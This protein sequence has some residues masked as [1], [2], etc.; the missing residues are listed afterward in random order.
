MTAPDP[1]NPAAHNAMA[2]L[3]QIEDDT[4]PYDRHAIANEA[5]AHAL[6]AVALELKIGNVLKAAEL[7]GAGV[8]DHDGLRFI[9]DRAVKG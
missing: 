9:R 1:T 7:E 6:L 4:L 8:L 2:L 3:D 5:T